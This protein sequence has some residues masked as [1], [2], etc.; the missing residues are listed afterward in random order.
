MDDI[1]DYQKRIRKILISTL[2][3]IF[4]V[5]IVF[6]FL[7]YRFFVSPPPSFFYGKYLDITN[8]MTVE[9]AANL[10]GDKKVIRSPVVFRI[11]VEL[12][13]VTPN[14]IAGEYKFDKPTNL[15]EVVRSV[16]DTSYKG[17]AVKVTVPEGFTNKDITDLLEERFP[18]FNKT[19]F[20]NLALPREGSLFPDTYIFPTS[21]SEE[22]IVNKMFD[23][24]Q[25]KFG[26]IK[27]AVI[28]SKRTRNEIIIMAS[29][30]EKEART[31]ETKKK[32]AGILWKRLDAGRPLQVDASFLY[33]LNKKSSDLTL[34]DLKIDSLYNTYKY[35]GFP[36]GA[37]SNPG[38]D[39]LKSALYPE[40][41]KYWFYL[42][43]ADGNMHYAVDFEEHKRNKV[44]YL[45]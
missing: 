30:L 25:T 23:N 1:E 35:K 38:L 5:S 9:E 34:D 21:F 18:N 28:K 11:F 2:A 39:S 17:R 7:F 16:T 15:Y 6:I 26:E 4:F 22:K 37:I 40:E 27:S 14:I 32:I 44:L 8:G 41:S 12:F 45:R 10:F 3:G 43:D 20:I 42:S 29:I 31:T 33:L 13:G 19:D 24:F 36:P